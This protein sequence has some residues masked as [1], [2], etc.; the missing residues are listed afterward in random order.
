M[1]FILVKRQQSNICWR[2]L[3]RKICFHITN[4]YRGNCSVWEV[5]NKLFTGAMGQNPWVERKNSCA[6]RKVWVRRTFRRREFHW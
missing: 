3:C 6:L 4:M 5:H 2:F 1:K